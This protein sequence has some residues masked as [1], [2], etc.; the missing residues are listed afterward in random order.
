VASPD[1]LWSIT[2]SFALPD[3]S[4]AITATATPAGGAESAPSPPLQITID[5][6]APAVIGSATFAYETAPHRLIYTFNEDLSQS[7][8]TSNLWLLNLGTSSVVGSGSMAVTFDAAGTAAT[9]SFPGLAQAVLEETNYRARLI[10]LADVA[11]NVSVPQA[12]VDLFFLRGDANH[13]R[14]VNLRDLSV[15]TSNWRQ[16]DGRVDELDLEILTLRWQQ[17]LPPPPAG[18]QA[19][20]GS[21]KPTAVRI[22]FASDVLPLVEVTDL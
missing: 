5:T 20:V 19:S 3:G 13:D 18:A 4:Y 17:S 14:V 12:A 2:T 10:D 11:G 7:L 21:A 15:L 16:T 22:P 1:G 6:V 9:F 8:S